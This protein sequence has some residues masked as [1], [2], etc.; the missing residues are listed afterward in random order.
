MKCERCHAELPAPEITFP[1]QSN[2]TIDVRLNNTTPL[3]WHKV[4]CSAC[5]VEVGK[6]LATLQ[7]GLDA[8]IFR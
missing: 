4:V 6:V 3:Y 8:L 7:D 1:R 2:V 5:F